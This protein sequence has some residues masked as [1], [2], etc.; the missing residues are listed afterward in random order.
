MFHPYIHG[1]VLLLSASVLGGRRLSALLKATSCCSG[2]GVS[3]GSALDSCSRFR[4]HLGCARSLGWALLG[5]LVGAGC[6]LLGMVCSKYLAM[7][8]RGK[9]KEESEKKIEKWYI[10]IRIQ[11]RMQNDFRLIRLPYR[12]CN[13]ENWKCVAWRRW[14]TQLLM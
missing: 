12:V 7:T 6:G 1:W 14:I 3:I 4:R 13:H 8:V 2:A 5:L 11:P 9:V 10:N